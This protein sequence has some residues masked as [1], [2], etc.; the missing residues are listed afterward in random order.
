MRPKRSSLTAKNLEKLVFLKGN[1]NLLKGRSRGVMVQGTPCL[2]KCIVVLSCVSCVLSAALQDADPDEGV[3]EMGKRGGLGGSARN[4]MLRYLLVAMA[5]PG[6]RYAAPQIL[7]RGVRRIGSEFLGKRSVAGESP[8]KMCEAIGCLPEDDQDPEDDLKKEQMSFTGQYNEPEDPDGLQNGPPKRAMGLGGMAHNRPP[9][10]FSLLP[11]RN[12]GSEF[13]GKRAMGSEFLGKRAMG[14]CVKQFPSLTALGPT[15]PPHP[16]PQPHHNPTTPTPPAIPTETA[17]PTTRGGSLSCRARAPPPGPTSNAG[18]GAAGR[19]SRSDIFHPALDRPP[20]KK[21]HP[22]TTGA[23]LPFS[24]QDEYRSGAQWSPPVSSRFLSSL[25]SSPPAASKQTLAW[26]RG[27]PAFP[28][29]HNSLCITPCQHHSGR[30]AVYL[31]G[32]VNRC[33]YGRAWTVRVGSEGP[34]MHHGCRSCAGLP[35]GSRTGG[36]RQCAGRLKDR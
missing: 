25:P 5:R 17:L 26:Q 29:L 3:G 16:P 24:S 9:R 34:M 20:R 7:S 2:T 35:S 1:M 21:K 36:P 30:V 8:E 23:Y 11:N 13:L 22:H 27:A 6:P 19:F 33:V 14:L 15:K 31:D 12:M 18:A 4:P 10:Y 32:F 28:C